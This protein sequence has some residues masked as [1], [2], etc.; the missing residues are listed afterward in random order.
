MIPIH[1]CSESCSDFGFLCLGFMWVR[2]RVVLRPADCTP[3]WLLAGGASDQTSCKHVSLKKLVHFQS[4][5]QVIPT[6][7]VIAKL[8]KPTGIEKGTMER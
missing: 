1:T 4:I 8:L 2:E 5:D 7:A 3:I 6:V